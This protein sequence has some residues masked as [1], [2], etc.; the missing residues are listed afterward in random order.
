MGEGYSSPNFE[1]ERGSGSPFP[2]A[3]PLGAAAVAL[4]AAGVANLLLARRAARLHPAMGRFITV[5]RVSLHY[6]ERGAGPV[7]VLLRGNGM[8]WDFVLSG[9]RN[10]LSRV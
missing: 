6:L 3:K 8:A 10:C 4:G 5:D 1:P 9:S 7:V 2:L